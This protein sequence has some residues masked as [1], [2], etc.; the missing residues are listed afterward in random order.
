MAD[1][2]LQ[3]VISTV[4]TTSNCCWKKAML[5]WNVGRFEDDIPESFCLGSLQ[6][7][8]HRVAESLISLFFG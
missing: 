8:L 4:S 7:G 1:L 6:L 2:L 3:H 5:S